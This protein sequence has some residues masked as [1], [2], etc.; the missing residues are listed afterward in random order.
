ME[1]KVSLSQEDKEAISQALFE[2]LKPYLLTGKEEDAILDKQA[3]A[4]YLKIS[5]A[6][7][8]RLVS[9]NEIPFIKLRDGKASAVRFRKRDIDRWLAR[10]TTPDK[11]G[12]LIFNHELMRKKQVK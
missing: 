3:L 5:V 8:N 2:K 10:K 1:L 4:E 12:N 11:S 9:N 6:Q 7:I